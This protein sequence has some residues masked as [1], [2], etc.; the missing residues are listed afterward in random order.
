MPT[1]LEFQEIDGSLWTRIDFK[2]ASE[3]SVSLWTEEEV[4][5][6]DRGLCRAIAE[7]ILNEPLDG[8]SE[9]RDRIAD[10]VRS[11]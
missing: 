9:F 11:F 6:H 4:Q 8:C 2:G 10:K 7:M 1:I 3:G 5:A